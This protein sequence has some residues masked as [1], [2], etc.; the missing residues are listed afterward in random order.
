MVPRITVSELDL[1]ALE[2]WMDEQGL[3]A[4][5]VTG[6]E[7]LGGGTQN[8]VV[9]LTRSDRRYVLRRPPFKARPGQDETMVREARV[10]AAL[11]GSDVPHP[12]PI[13]LCEDPGVL[14]AAF[15]LMEPIEGFNPGDGLPEP[16]QHD[17]GL[18]MVDI[19]AALA[20]V[21][22]EAAGLGDLGRADEWL[23][24][25]TPRCVARL[26]RY[27]ET[28]GYTPLDPGLVDPVAEWLEAHR[29][30]GWVLGLN[31]G[32]FHLANVMV[33][34]DEPRVVAV[35][36]WELASIGDPLLDLAHLLVTW[37]AGGPG[38][39]DVGPS[40]SLPS[41]DDLIARYASRTD[42]PLDDL[43]WYRVL[44]GLRMA[45]IL[46]ATVARAAAGMAAPDLA[47]RFRESNVALLRAAL[48][49]A[50]S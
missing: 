7:E 26:S 30:A 17:V 9:A 2:R 15:Y 32:D 41:P 34:H 44:A 25:Q 12:R 45:S 10:L 29:P 8:V 49:A 43:P 18:H 24:R 6:V 31:H 27:A 11:E 4:G 39:I 19:L 42:R 35:V 13:A 48:T 14:G 22:V 20:R 28:P 36:D 5:P 38:L 23:E 33:A 16:M 3:G 40:S 21:D 46:E 50:G 47:A 37:P 1:G